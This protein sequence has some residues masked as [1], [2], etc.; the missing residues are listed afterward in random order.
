VEIPVDGRGQRKVAD[1]ESIIFP[2]Q[3]GNESD[4]F[5]VQMSLRLL[6]KLH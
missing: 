3:G 4:G 2:V 5:D 1:G 6:L